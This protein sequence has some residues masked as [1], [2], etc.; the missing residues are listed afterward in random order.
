MPRDRILVGG[1]KFHGYHGF[2]KLEQQ[3]GVRCSIDVELALDL[4]AASRSDD[5]KDTIDYREVHKMVLALGQG[6]GSYHLIE[7]LAARIADKLLERF[8]VPEVTVRVRK[9]TPVLDGIVDYVGAEV[10]RTR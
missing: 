1:I 8:D 7:A 6:G 5:L 10:T 3:V 4:D 2:T 9:E